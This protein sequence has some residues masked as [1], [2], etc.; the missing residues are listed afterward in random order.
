MEFERFGFYKVDVDYL[1]YLNEK[2]SEVYYNSSYAK[3]LKPFLGIIIAINLH[4]YFIPLTSAKEKHIK[5]KNSSDAHFL[6]YETIDKC[7]HIENAIVKPFSEKEQMHILAV[8]DIKKMIPVPDGCYEAI[9][10]NSL[11]SRYRDLFRKEYAFCL[12]V[13]DKIISKS[14]NTYNK[15]LETSKILPM[16]CNYKK[17]EELCKNYKNT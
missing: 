1:K 8:L 11:D 12:K 9:D 17:L 16:H 7:V 14:C 15:Q 4:K 5:W 3:D 10:F 13:K 6:I 2:D